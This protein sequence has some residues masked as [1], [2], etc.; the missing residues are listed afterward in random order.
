MEGVANSLRVSDATGTVRY[1]QVWLSLLSLTG[2]IFLPVASRRCGSVYDCRHELWC[3]RY[4]RIMQW[5]K[6]CSDAPNPNSF[7]GA[8]VTVT[9]ICMRYYCIVM[10]RVLLLLCCIVTLLYCYSVILL[11]YSIVT[12]FYCYY[13]LLLLCSIVTLFYYYS[14]LLWLYSI[15]TLF[16]YSIILLFQLHS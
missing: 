6:I 14:V 13:I 11:L 4:G 3:P 16:H 2:A 7:G 5:R 9:Q 12:L 1:I 8:Q 15:V 10:R